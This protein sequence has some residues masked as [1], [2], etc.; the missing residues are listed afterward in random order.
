MSEKNFVLPGYLKL[1]KKIYFLLLVLVCNYSFGQYKF[2]IE[3]KV[4][5]STKRMIYLE[6]RD[7]YSLNEFIKKDSC[8]I[9]RG[10]FK[11]SGEIKKRSEIANIFFFDQSKNIIPEKFRFVLDEGFNAITIDLPQKQSKSLYTNAKRPSS[12]SNELYNK[13]NNLYEEYFEKYASDVKSWDPKKPDDIVFIKMLDN[14][15]KTVELRAK[16]LEE[17]KKYPNTFYSLIFLY[18]SIHYRPYKLSPSSLVEI[19]NTLNTTIKS[20]PLGVEFEQLAEKISKVAIETSA[21]HQ[22]P[23]FKIKTDKGENFTNASL[24]G[25]PY[26]IAFSATWCAPCKERE[27]ALKSLYDSYKSKGLEVVYFNFDDND[28]KWKEH[29]SKNQL[30]WINV[31]DGLKAGK[32]PIIEQFNIIGIPHYIIVGRKGDI[33]YNSRSPL[34]R[35]FLLLEKN[36][37]KATQ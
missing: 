7:D 3:G 36:I 32:S 31:S 10:I 26:I 16:Q 14:P 13:M 8:I 30:N 20:D 33:L 29:I 22:V 19:F 21:L 4:E 15:E 1:I 35:D 34:D 17:L 2:A 23:I 24:L 28:K 18:E 25:K 12:L 5:D 9:E 6:I 37:I 11:F 27:P